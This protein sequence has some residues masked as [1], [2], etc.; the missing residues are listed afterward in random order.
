MNMSN[1]MTRLYNKIKGVLLLCLVFCSTCLE[2]KQPY[3]LYNAKGKKSSFTKMVKS[4]K[5]K[6]IILFGEIHNSP[7]AHWLEIEVTKALYTPQLVLGAEMF[8]ADNQKAVDDF[9]S[10]TIDAKGLDT[11]CRLWSNYKTDY[12]ALL[13]YAKEKKLPFVATNI[14]R[15]YATRVYKHG[16]ESL[17]KDSLTNEERHWIAPLPIPYDPMLPRYQHILSMMG[18]HGTP[19]LVKAQAIKDAT[20]AHFIIKNYQEGKQ[21][22]HFNGAYHSDFYEGIL[23]Y[24]M[25]QNQTYRYG[26]I[27]TVEQQDISQLEQEH[28]GKADFIICVDEDVTT[29]Y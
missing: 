12:A 7:I 26:T 27:S 11:L 9:L 15:V 6:D 23:W 28:I 2:A 24:L 17:H 14:P 4:L 13:A 20:M 8:E 25:K 1:I 29:S 10:S 16:F 21:F 18:D 19:E 22:L 3:A 5:Q